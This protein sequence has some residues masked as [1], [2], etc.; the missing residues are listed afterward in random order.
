[1][2]TV[3]AAIFGL[4]VGVIGGHFLCHEKV[5]AP[6]ASHASAADLAAI[7]KLHQ[8]DIDVT[9]TQNPN[10]LEEL[11]SEDGV[12]LQ[13]DGTVVVGRK[14][15]GADN[16]KFWAANPGF[17]VLR[18]EPDLQHFSMAVADGWAVETGTLAATFK[19]SVKDEPVKTN[20][21]T[22]RLLQRQTDGSWK[23]ALVKLM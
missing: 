14:A 17:K 9:L 2:K 20:I 22:L 13:P 12:R 16:E 11:W 23:F 19:M 10:G 6:A 18:Y 7:G 3:M 1:M 21:K 15:I 4:L 8:Q 5:D